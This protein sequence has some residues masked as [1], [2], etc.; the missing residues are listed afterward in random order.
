VEYSAGSPQEN[1]CNVAEV[2]RENLLVEILFRHAIMT[3]KIVGCGD[4]VPNP[5]G[6]RILG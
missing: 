6:S 1:D 5:T 4:P 3:F 2:G